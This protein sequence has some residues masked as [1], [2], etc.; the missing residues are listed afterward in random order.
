MDLSYQCHIHTE[1]ERN[2]VKLHKFYIQANKKL[3]GAKHIQLYKIK[4]LQ[5]TSSYERVKKSQRYTELQISSI[6]TM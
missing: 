5:D 6:E 1:D 4:L 3:L 2:Y